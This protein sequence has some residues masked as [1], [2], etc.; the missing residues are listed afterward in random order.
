M[1][2]A[3]AASNVGS[4]HASAAT[5]P[6]KRRRT[7]RSRAPGTRPA[8][9]HQARVRRRDDRV[10]ALEHDDGA[11]RCRELARRAEAVR[12]DLHGG[13]AREGARA[14]PG[15]GVRIAFFAAM[16]TLGRPANMVRASASTTMGPPS[17]REHVLDRSARVVAESE[18]RADDDSLLARQDRVEALG[19]LDPARCGRSSPRRTCDSIARAAS[20]QVAIVA[21]PAPARMAP[22]ATSWGAPILP[23][24]PAIDDDVPRRV[25]V[26]LPVSAGRARGRGPLPAASCADAAHVG[27]ERARHADVDD[28]DAPGPTRAAGREKAELVMGERRRGTRLDGD[29]ERRPRVGVEP[30]RHVD[31]EARRPPSALIART[32]SASIPRWGGRVPCRR[33]HRR[34]RP[35]RPG[36]GCQSVDRRP[37]SKLVHLAAE[38]TPRIEVRPRVRRRPAPDPRVG[39]PRARRHADKRCL[40]TTSPSPPLFPVPHATMMRAPSGLPPRSSRTRTSVA[41]RPAFSIRTRLGTPH[42]RW[43]AASKARI[44]AREKTGRH[45]RLLATRPATPRAM[46]AW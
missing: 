3:Q 8:D 1:T 6:L 28:V 13:L 25:L 18:A 45:A 9:H 29:A 19:R 33:A 24:E 35:P 44:C 39:R 7:R 42:V 46:A 10:R 34:P 40:A 36:L 41:P 20:G 12:L 37:G 16:S 43:R 27:H 31:R 26:L 17:R 22:R 21:R 2:P 38:T 23:G 32:T 15:C 14:S 5:T 30:G 4:E 11:V